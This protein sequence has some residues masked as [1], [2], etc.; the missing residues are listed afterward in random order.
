M[1]SSFKLSL[2]L[3]SACLAAG[4]ASLLKDFSIVGYSEEDLASHDRLLEL[5]ESWMSKHGRVYESMEEKLRRFQ[6]FKGNLLHIDQANRRRASYWLGLNEFAD[7]SHDEFKARYLGVKVNEA[8]ERRASFSSE[9][10]F[11]YAAAKPLPKAVDWRKKG[12]VT[13][14]KNQG[15]CGKSSNDFTA[16]VQLESSFYRAD[17]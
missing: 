5:F 4:S 12:A 8:R 2:V 16:L 1:A 10:S 14:V 7:L 13:R 17:N 3:L 11:R 15:G 9:G 6:V